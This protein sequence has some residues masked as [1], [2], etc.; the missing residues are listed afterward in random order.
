MIYSSKGTAK[1]HCV[2]IAEGI[3]V[4]KKNLLSII[5]CKNVFIYCKK[6]IYY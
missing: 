1:E 3:S 2:W 5:N 4:N 6:F